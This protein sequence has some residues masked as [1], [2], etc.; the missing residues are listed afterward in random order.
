MTYHDT[1]FDRNIN[2]TIPFRANS[3]TLSNILLSSEFIHN[4]L[5]KGDDPL[6]LSILKWIKIKKAY[7]FITNEG[8]KDA[9]YGDIYYYIGSSKCALCITALEKYEQENG[10]QKYPKDKCTK[11]KLSHIESC[12]DVNSLFSNITYLLG[13]WPTQYSKN[14]P[15]ID[16][17]TLTKDQIH[18]LLGKH[19][20][21]M[22]KRLKSI[23]KKP[24]DC[25]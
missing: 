12:P 14:Q 16:L 23:K 15:I 20:R 3:P 18:A 10:C 13:Y 24:G 9:Y 17:K 11:C 6:Y 1:E 8:F 22:I 5:N 21:E 7:D 25:T 19:I 2:G 4:R